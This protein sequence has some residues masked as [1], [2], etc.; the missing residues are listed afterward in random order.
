MAAPQPLQIGR[1]DQ[2]FTIGT[3]PG[4]TPPPLTPSGK[5]DLTAA[6]P[7]AVQHRDVDPHGP[8]E[9]IPAIVELDDVSGSHEIIQEEL[10]LEGGPG[11]RRAQPDPSSLKSVPA[12][13]NQGMPSFAQHY[14]PT[15]VSFELPGGAGSFRCL[16]HM[17]MLSRSQSALLLGIKGVLPGNAVF[18]P[19]VGAGLVVVV[20]EGENAVRYKVVSFGAVFQIDDW[21]MTVLGITGPAEAP[22]TNG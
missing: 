2:R 1:P 13:V 15:P 8:P 10:P 16:Y 7:A 6:T 9:P 17:V 22:E 18:E 21:H 5:I 19:G 4:K 11:P 12:N 3:S 20:D 14:K